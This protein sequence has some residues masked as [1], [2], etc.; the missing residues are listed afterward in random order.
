MGVV[1]KK[2]FAYFQIWN[3]IINGVAF[4]WVLGRNLQKKLNINKCCFQ[5]EVAYKWGVRL[6]FLARCI[7]ISS[8]VFDPV[9]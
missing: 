4:K 2:H 7:S 6:N 5:N 9:S 3:L 1:K 8:I